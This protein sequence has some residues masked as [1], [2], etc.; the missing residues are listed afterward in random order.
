M[1]DKNPL[2]TSILIPDG[3]SH[4]LIYVINCLSQIPGV[5]IFVMSSSKNN[6]PRFSRYISNFKYY[7]KTQNDLEWI[8]HINTETKKHEIEIIMPIF[9][10]GIRKI[11]KN[12]EYLNPD[13]LV[14]PLPDIKT[15]T[16][17]INKWELAN[18]CKNNEINVPESVLYVPEKGLS[19]TSFEALKFPVIVKPLE[20]FG[21]GMGI[22]VI[23]T[24][25]DLKTYLR[26]KAYLPTIIQD[27]IKGYD[28]DCS[29]L[30]EDGKIK[31]YTIQKGYLQGHTPFMPH[32]GITFI[33]NPQLL[34]TVQK[35]I[36][37]LQ[38][39]GI[40]HLDLRYDEKD[41]T[42]KVIELN[43]RFWVTVDASCLMGVNF[44]HLLIRQ[45]LKHTFS[46]PV[47][48][49]ENYL[50]LK[51]IVKT[52]KK[53]FFFIKRTKFILNNTQFRFVIYDPVPTVYKYLDRTKN[54]V[55]R[56]IKRK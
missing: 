40:A 47:F 48:K 7:P 49:H 11:I 32:V 17:A 22:D 46:N 28:I 41:N 50:N 14:V 25:D 34:N 9:E 31:A 23:E 55:L 26:E 36:S 54:I 19:A 20:G 16:T 39:N 3:E 38:W 2:S 53:D 43:P 42:Y 12:K 35:L 27:F 6:P 30:A 13:T 44:P 29:I 8:Q 33:D 18:F 21:G 15:F 24:P 5:S 51:G 52:I 10:T 45:T 37:R 56:K 1:S 4:L